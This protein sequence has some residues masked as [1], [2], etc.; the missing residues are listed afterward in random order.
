M[1]GRGY[2]ESIVVHAGNGGWVVIDSFCDHGN[3]DPAPLIYLKDIGVDVAKDVTAVVLTHLHDDHYRG[4]ETVVRECESAWFYLPGVLPHP[5]WQKILERAARLPLGEAVGVGQVANA[6]RVASGR[7]RLRIAGADSEIQ[8]RRKHA[9]CCVGPTSAA[10]TSPVVT[11]DP[12]D[13]V[14][15]K[16]LKEVN[17]TS[18]VLW[19]D[20]GG[21][22]ALLGADLDEH[23]P[24]L[25][26]SALMA[27][28][29]EK[30]WIQGASLVK[31][32]HHTSSRAHCAALHEKWCTEPV[33]VITAN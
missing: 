11:D 28:Q 23:D 20:T 25:G 32:P 22:R 33:A 5:R 14:I 27:E 12:S 21:I 2:G 13:A 4:I 7:R 8:T 18:T 15:R 17:F 16:L 10:L 31:V 29:Q 26:W 9:I 30:P 24:G 6:A 1:L 3:H 19:L